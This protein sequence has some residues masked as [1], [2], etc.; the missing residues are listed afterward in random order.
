[1]GLPCTMTWNFAMAKAFVNY[2]PY[3]LQLGTGIT[4][5]QLVVQLLCAFVFTAGFN[6]LLYPQVLTCSSSPWLHFMLIGCMLFNNILALSSSFM[7][8]ALYSHGWMHSFSV[9]GKWLTSV[10]QAWQISRRFLISMPSWKNLF[11]WFCSSFFHHCKFLSYLH[12]ML[13][14]EVTFWNPYRVFF[15]FNSLLLAVNWASL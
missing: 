13:V 6:P 10:Y 12:S 4:C 1:M 11:S 2:Q 9:V 8:H 7:D 15:Q 3:S 5:S 14:P